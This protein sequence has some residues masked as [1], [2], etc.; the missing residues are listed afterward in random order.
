MLTHFLVHE[1]RYPDD[2]RHE[3]AAFDDD[4]LGLRLLFAVPLVAVGHRV[5]HR[6]VPP[7]RV[8][9]GV[10]GRGP[11]LAGTDKRP[12]VPTD[13]RLI[14]LLQKDSRDSSGPEKYFILYDISTI[15][16]ML[17]SSL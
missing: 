6:S 2:M 4:A 9:V 13:N 8:V 17:F 1:A 3:L 14:N 5:A 7:T 12:A 10:G 16:F 15:Y 11:R